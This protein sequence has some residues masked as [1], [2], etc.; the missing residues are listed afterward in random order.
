[1]ADFSTNV[2]E[3]DGS[4]AAPSANTAIK[5]DPWGELA[6]KLIPGVIEGVGKGYAAAQ[7][8][9]VQG[10]NTTATEAEQAVNDFKAAAPFEKDDNDTPDR[11][12]EIEDM[13]MSALKKFGT[14]DKRIQALV[15]AGKISTTEANARRSQMLQEKLSN[16]ILAMF[17]DDF[18]DASKAFTG[19]SGSASEEYNGAYIPTVEERAEKAAIDKIIDQRAKHKAAVEQ[20]RLS[21]GVT[22]EQAND[23]V[24]EQSRMAAAVDAA[25]TKHKLRQF[26]S[27]ESFDAAMD[28]VDLFTTQGGGELM[29]MIA[30]GKKIADPSAAMARL[31]GIQNQYRAKLAEYRKTMTPE[32]YL[33]VEGE[34]NKRMN[35]W[36]EVIKNAD[37]TEYTLKRLRVASASADV[38]LAQSQVNMLKTIGPLYNL[39]RYAP[40]YAKVVQG[41]LDGDRGAQMAFAQNTHLQGV[42]KSLGL[43]KHIKMMPDVIDFMNN[44]NKVRETGVKKDEPSSF[45]KALTYVSSLWSGGSQGI[46]AEI[47]MNKANPD[48]HVQLLQKNFSNKEVSLN[49]YSNSSDWI[50]MA[51]TA[52]GAKAVAAAVK[53]RVASAK[54]RQIGM[55]DIPSI[56]MRVEQMDL[57]DEMGARGGGTSYTINVPSGT[58]DNSVKDDLIQM[59]KVLNSSPLVLK[60]LGYATPDAAI[61]NYFNFKNPP[62]VNEAREKEAEKA[63]TK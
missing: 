41:V 50:A 39:Q 48:A 8:A 13:R 52:D 46:K 24:T 51:K 34:M 17:K 43:E 9:N 59:Y 33:R 22:Q 28:V 16:P 26:N 61:E 14:D 56:K 44:A 55:G 54:E 10:A 1:M 42:V 6:A 49:Y 15:N 36:E 23:I 60:E 20:V 58:L 40:E 7:G 38:T 35:G 11:R 19:G 45:A 32:D 27:A 3:W 4:Y 21:M 57:N 18:L 29:S 37:A 25:E 63:K 2:K 5:S 31:Q 53:A 62:V 30:G 12:A 47:E